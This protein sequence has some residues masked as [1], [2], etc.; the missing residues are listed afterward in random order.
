MI[1]AKAQERTQL[2]GLFLETT[3]S[4]RTWRSEVKR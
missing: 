3:I 1:S 4:P 2:I